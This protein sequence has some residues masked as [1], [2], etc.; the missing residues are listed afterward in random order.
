MYK[1]RIPKNDKEN[2]EGLN[3]YQLKDGEVQ[4]I[5]GN[6][7]TTKDMKKSLYPSGRI[8]LLFRKGKHPLRYVSAKV[9]NLSLYNEPNAD[10]VLEFKESDRLL[11]MD[12]KGRIQ[13]SM[14]SGSRIF[15]IPD[16]K[17]LIK[18]A[19]SS[20]F[21]ELGQKMIEII[22]RQDTQDPEY[23]ND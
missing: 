17:D 20:K 8:G 2:R 18:L 16:T 19:K 12:D 6:T 21:E 11:V 10:N 15:S 1:L 3:N 5:H 9:G 22:E 7:I 13:G 14:K 4:M 23:V